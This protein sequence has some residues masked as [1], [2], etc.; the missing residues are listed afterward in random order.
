MTALII[1][2]ANPNIMSKATRLA[3]DSMH[4]AVFVIVGVAPLSQIL[5]PKLIAAETTVTV[6]LREACPCIKRRVSA[7]APAH[8]KNRYGKKIARRV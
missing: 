3:I 6:H 8:T 4:S 1:S 7:R 5:G 2:I